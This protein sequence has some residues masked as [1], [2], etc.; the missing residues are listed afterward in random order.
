MSVALPDVGVLFSK[1]QQTLTKRQSP[2]RVTVTTVTHAAPVMQHFFRTM[3]T[4]GYF[5]L[6]LITRYKSPR[7]ATLTPFFFNYYIS[8]WTTTMWITRISLPHITDRKCWKLT[9][10]PPGQRK[11]LRFDSILVIVRG[12][13]RVLRQTKY[14]YTQSPL[15][16]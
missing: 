9:A 5:F 7:N 8:N 15:L 14:S 12:G 2:C 11:A 3:I 6:F 1:M 10:L 13:L 16:V 4:T